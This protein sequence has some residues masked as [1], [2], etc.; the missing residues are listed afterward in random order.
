MSLMPDWAPG[1][2]PMIV[3]FPI[4]LLVAAAVADGFAFFAKVPGRS[5]RAAAALFIA[6]SLAAVGAYFAGQAAA[7]GV[8]LP[9]GSESVVESHEAWA[10]WTMVYFL[11]Y[12]VSR[13]IREM[14]ARKPKRALDFLILSL[15][16]VGLL[17]LARTSEYGAELV[18]R[19]GV[20]VEAVSEQAEGTVHD[21]GAHGTIRTEPIPH[22]DTDHSH[23]V[24]KR[25]VI[26]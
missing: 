17:L 13:L 2:H 21:H 16:F 3:H 18:Y 5:R 22:G 10:W 12:A 4:A 6:G 14:A 20:G 11:L 24:S 8:F 15:G 19:Y 7:D 26:E 9:S 1:I 25:R 23:G